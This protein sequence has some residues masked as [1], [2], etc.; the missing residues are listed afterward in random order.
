[1]REAKDAGNDL[2]D[3]ALGSCLPVD[4]LGSPEDRL[5]YRSEPP[6]SPA[7]DGWT[8]D[9][10]G[11]AKAARRRRESEEKAKRRTV[12]EGIRQKVE[13]LVRHTLAR[14]DPNLTVRDL[15][16]FGVQVAGISPR[17]RW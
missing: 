8:L 15:R 5:P 1:M 10:A 16:S 4:W 3:F 7:H 6:S 14:I 9:Y 2:H 11:I 13:S 17:S 12:R